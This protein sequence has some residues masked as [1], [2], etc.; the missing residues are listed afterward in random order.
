MINLADKV[1]PDIVVE[2]A[3]I[4]I[5]RAPH[6]FEFAPRGL[7]LV[8]VAVIDLDGDHVVRVAE[9]GDRREIKPAGGDAVF[10]KADEL[11]VDPKAPGLF[12]ALE[13]EED[14][15]VLGAGRQLE[16]F[17]I[18][19]DAPQRRRGLRRCG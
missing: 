13:F 18:P 7:L 5:E 16:V 8:V 2:A 3:V 4:G 10:K 1:E 9:M 15:A 6:P 17:A 11:A 19:G 14:F 12:Q